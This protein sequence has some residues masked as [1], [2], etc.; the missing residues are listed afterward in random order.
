M[1]ASKRRTKRKRRT[2]YWLVEFT[3]KNANVMEHP[4]TFKSLR[5]VS[6]YIGIPFH[7]LTKFFYKED[8]KTKK[9]KD[10]M[11]HLI[12]TPVYSD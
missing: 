1:N 9:Y 4:F 7:T 12:I 3:F 2:S 8:Y 5:A 11:D 6:D 10:L